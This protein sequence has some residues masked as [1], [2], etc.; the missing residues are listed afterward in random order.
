MAVIASTTYSQLFGFSVRSLFS[1]LFVPA[2]DKVQ[3]PEFLPNSVAELMQELEAE[4]NVIFGTKIEFDDAIAEDRNQHTAESRN[5][6]LDAARRLELHRQRYGELEYR[7]S[8]LQGDRFE[9]S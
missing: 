7:A 1:K 4:T 5:R 8:V 9:E 3:A 2:K 6:V